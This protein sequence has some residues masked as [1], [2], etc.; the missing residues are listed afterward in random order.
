MIKYFKQF[1][2]EEINIGGFEVQ[3]EYPLEIDTVYKISLEEYSKLQ[4]KSLGVSFDVNETEEFNIYFNKRNRF[5]QVGQKV[6][7]FNKVFD[8]FGKPTKKISGQIEKYKRFG[9]ENETF[10][11]IHF[12]LKIKS[13]SDYGR[14]GYL[15]K[16]NTLEEMFE[17][18]DSFEE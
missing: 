13:G 7:S 2:N 18:F 8:G 4:Q 17:F 1:I 9:E 3:S 5:T 15:L 12:Y 16:M 14:D 11:I 10:Y 6:Y